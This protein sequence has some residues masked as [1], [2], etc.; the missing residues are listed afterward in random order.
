M[1]LNKEYITQLYDEIGADTRE[2][3]GINSLEDFIDY[4]KATITSN[5]QYDLDLEIDGEK[6]F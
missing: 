6:L 5:L 1:T 4:I 2:E 3:L